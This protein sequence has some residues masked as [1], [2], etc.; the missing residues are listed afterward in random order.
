MMGLS[1]LVIKMSRCQANFKLS[2]LEPLGGFR[3][4]AR[5]YPPFFSTFDV[6]LCIHSAI[7][8]INVWYKLALYR[9]WGLDLKA[10]GPP[11][12]LLQLDPLWVGFL[13]RYG[14]SWKFDFNLKRRQNKIFTLV[15]CKHWIVSIFNHLIGE[16]I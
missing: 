12:L 7:T 6:V 4:L 2:M 14:E 13:W 9:A 1:Y 3:L 16:V 8:A 15:H 11:V 5:L 10:K